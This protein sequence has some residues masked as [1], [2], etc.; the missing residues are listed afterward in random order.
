MRGV[1][2]DGLDKVEG[3]RSLSARRAGLLGNRACCRA[4]VGGI[5]CRW[6]R[7]HK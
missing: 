6:S 3:T 5:N 4:L 1:A 7:A 2:V